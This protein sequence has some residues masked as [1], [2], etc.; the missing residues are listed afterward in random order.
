MP[1]HKG[2]KHEIII[3]SN[4]IP[5]IEL[6]KAPTALYSLVDRSIDYMLLANS[7]LNEHEFDLMLNPVIENIGSVDIKSRNKLI[8]FGYNSVMLNRKKIEELL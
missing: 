4:V 8:Q 6:A 5:N 7:R 1:L 2:Y 3:G